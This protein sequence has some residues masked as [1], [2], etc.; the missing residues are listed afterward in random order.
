[1]GENTRA[2]QRVRPVWVEPMQ[3]LNRIKHPYP[4]NIVAQ[5]CPK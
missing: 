3:G 1:M 5:R 4:Q 2:A